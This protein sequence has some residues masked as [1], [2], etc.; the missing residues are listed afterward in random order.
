MAWSSAISALSVQA[1]MVEAIGDTVSVPS[2]N[3]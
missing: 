1:I 3:V 2:A